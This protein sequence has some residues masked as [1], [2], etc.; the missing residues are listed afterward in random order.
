MKP[1]KRQAKYHRYS[2]QFKEEACNLARN[3]EVGPSKAAE[4]LGVHENTLR[5][6]FQQR[7]G[8]EIQQLPD[9]P[10]DLKAQIRQLQK[11]LEQARIDQEILKKAAAYFARSQP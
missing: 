9:D 6:W 2:R 7:G 1:N 10:A 4:R 3:P 8:L 11:Q 5:F